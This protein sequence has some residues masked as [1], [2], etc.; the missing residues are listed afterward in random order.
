MENLD[1]NDK[2]LCFYGIGKIDADI[3]GDIIYQNKSHNTQMKGNLEII[4]HD[5]EI[6]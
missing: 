1:N 2:G 6:F 4:T 5:N 3:V